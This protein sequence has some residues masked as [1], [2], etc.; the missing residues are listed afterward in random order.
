VFIAGMEEGILPH[1]NSISQ[2]DEETAVEEER[3]LFYVGIT[4]AR[5]RLFLSLARE[6]TRFGAS[7][8]REMSRF[9]EEVGMDRLKVT[10]SR[11]RA[12]AAPEMGREMMRQIRARFGKGETEEK[13]ASPWWEEVS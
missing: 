8:E 9:L 5:E 13:K 6:R 12:P 1:K 3:R 11:D 7:Q 2:D 4:R 10:D